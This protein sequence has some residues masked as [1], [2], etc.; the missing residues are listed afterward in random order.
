[1]DPQQT[2]YTEFL[3]AIGRNISMLVPESMQRMPHC[4]IVQ[5]RM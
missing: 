3:A 2:T 4:F 1:M 5:Q